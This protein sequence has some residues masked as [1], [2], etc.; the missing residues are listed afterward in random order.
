MRG[1]ERCFIYNYRVT[2]DRIVVKYGQGL[3]QWPVGGQLPLID[4]TTLV[5]P[6]DIHFHSN[7]ATFSFRNLITAHVNYTRSPSH[8]ASHTEVCRSS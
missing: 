7:A 8:N 4:S 1:V 6:L 2:E 3:R 5:T